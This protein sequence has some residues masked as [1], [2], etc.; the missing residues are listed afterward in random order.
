VPGLD[1][2]THV[3]FLS[4]VKDVDGRVKPGQGVIVRGD[5]CKKTEGGCSGMAIVGAISQRIWDMKYRLR[6]PSGEAVDKTI[7]DTWQRVA[8][9]LAAPG[10]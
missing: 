1:P 2:G 4:K 8:A 6:A 3:L 7:E 9:A 10:T 5:R